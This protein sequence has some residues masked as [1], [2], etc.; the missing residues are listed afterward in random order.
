MAK[1]MMRVLQVLDDTSVPA[2]RT[3]DAISTRLGA[4][5][6]EV[7]EALFRLERAG[8]VSVEGQCRGIAWRSDRTPGEHGTRQPSQPGPGDGRALLSDDGGR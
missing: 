7:F 5:Q 3:V 2:E 6:E 8:I 4:R 1:M